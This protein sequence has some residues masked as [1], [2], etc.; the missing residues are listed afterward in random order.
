MIKTKKLQIKF[1]ERGF[2]GKRK[3][4]EGFMRT[5]INLGVGPGEGLTE[6]HLSLNNWSAIFIR[7]HLI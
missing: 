3:G 5:R 4:R 2:W 6:K 7:Y 1:E